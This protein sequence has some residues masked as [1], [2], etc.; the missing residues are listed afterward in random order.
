MTPAIHRFAANFDVAIGV[1]NVTARRSASVGFC[2]SVE[3]GM[4][5]SLLVLTFKQ[6]IWLL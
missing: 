3:S 4:V 6:E 5:L 2:F 1:A